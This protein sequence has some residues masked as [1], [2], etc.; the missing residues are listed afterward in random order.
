MRSTVCVIVLGVLLSGVRAFLPV[1]SGGHTH[2]TITRDAVM[3]SINEVC[4]AE[5][6]SEGREFKPTDSSVEELLNACLGSTT[7]L[8]SA[9]KFHEALNQIY[10]QHGLVDRDFMASNMHHFNGETFTEG[11]ILITQG[12][13][14]VK[15][16]TLKGNVQAARETLGRVLHTLQD[17]YSHSNWVELGNKKTHPNLIRRDF[18]ISNVADV[19]TPTCS[20]CAS[21]TCPNQ[22]LPSILSKKEL[23]S[24]YLGL[25]SPNKPKGKCSHGGDSDLSSTQDP[26]GGI[27]KDEL[28][29]HNADLHKAAVTL[30]TEASF[31]LLENIL[32][33]VGNKDYL[34]LMG[35]TRSVV[36][37]FVIDTTGSM[38]DDIA[39][40]K[41]VAHNIIDE[42]KG[43][44]DEPSEYILVPFNDPEFGPLMRTTDPNKMKAEI[45]KLG[46]HGGGDAPEMCMSGLQ[47]AL[48]GS[49]TS[50]EIYVFTDAPAKD[51][52]LEKTVFALIDSTQST[53]SFY[54]TSEGR[55]RRSTVHSDFQLY[56]DLALAS[57]GQAIKVSKSELPSATDIII[58]T[59]TSALVTILQ[60][61]RKT[62]NEESFSFLLDS[63]VS[64]VIAYITG[65]SLKFTLQ[66]PSGVSQSD[67][68]GPGSLAKVQ[69]VGNLWRLQFNSPT[70]T[71][72][73]TV[74]IVSKKTYT[75]RIIGQSD[76]TFIY[77]F[78]EKF[79]GPHPG[80]A[81]IEGRP[82][83][84]KPT[85]LWLTV[86]GQKVAEDLKIQEVGLVDV[87][88]T[89]VVDGKIHPMGG[90][91]FLVTVSE[92]PEGE[93][94]IML[95]GEETATSSRFQRQS[96]T[97][98]SLSKITVK[99]TV[100]STLLPGEPFKLPF[101]V[102]TT[103][104]GGTYTI[105][106]R[107]DRGFPLTYNTKLNL[108]TGVSAKSTVVVKPPANTE[109]GT[110]IALTIVAEGPGGFETNYAV[111]RLTVLSKVTDIT[112]PVC[113][114]V[115]VNAHCP[116]DCTQSNWDLAVNITDGN[117]VGIENI[118]IQQGRGN[119]SQETVVNGGITVVNGNYSAS[120]CSPDVTLSIVDKEGNVGK[121]S[122]SVSEET[123]GLAF[124]FYLSLQAWFGIHGGYMQDIFP[125]L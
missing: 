77:N 39:E 109:S 103:G 35:I 69:T 28:R 104:A 89:R 2:V 53:V 6:E 48:T 24:G 67:G 121:C 95:K 70:E 21:G 97:Q 111:L 38:A 52:H 88:G 49:P 105:S 65:D 98:M 55:S 33:A 61:A 43:T 3:K 45:S 82:Q 4:K 91:D 50:S 8:V 10:L 57:G 83:T 123:G 108:E 124:H 40:A 14:A 32:G 119:F 122:H 20:D 31:E 42:K 64:K 51:T 11:Q 58:D 60:R 85:T 106:A 25:S 101:T 62:G 27:N 102:I 99:A 47:L 30:A 54:Q 120:C 17:F 22:L 80:F 113:E 18:T 115:G 92:V 46:A 29:A 76:I 114:I 7:G 13:A 93:F 112:P 72:L 63:S 110:D 96:T 78:V 26:R 16:N 1:G 75:I 56:S 87:S 19:D 37:C 90:G 5:A 125:L 9:T 44:Q 59:S 68:V 107:N 118:F 34:R 73:W 86:T 117:G 94:V 41:R 84:G 23:T 81:I 12:M 15:S 66:S 74:R 100:D 79:E 36:L 71:G 116:S